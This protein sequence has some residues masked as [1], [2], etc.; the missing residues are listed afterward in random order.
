MDE[1]ENPFE[2]DDIVAFC[3]EAASKSDISGEPRTLEGEFPGS[4]D[5]AMG[6]ARR[7]VEIAEENGLDADV[8]YVE[9]EGDFHRIDV[10]IE[11]GESQ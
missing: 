8:E 3:F 4:R 5:R 11:G 7:V 10:H 2:G 1:L 6:H 9:Q